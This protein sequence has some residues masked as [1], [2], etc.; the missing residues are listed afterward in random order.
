M[1]LQRLAFLLG[2]LFAAYFLHPTVT[3]AQGTAE[4]HGTLTDPS[5]GA[6]S[7]AS[8]AAHSLDSSAAIVRAKSEPNGEYSLKLAPG[9]YR[10]SIEH[11]SFARAEQEFVLTAGE[12]RA[13]DVR[14]T[15]EK[16][17]SRVVVTD[18]AEPTT[19]ENAPNLVDVIT[20]GEIEERQD[21]QLVDVLS[22]RQGASFSRLGPEGGITS[23]FL[24]G[25]NSNFTKIL[26]DGTPVNEP[27]GAI[28]LSNFTTDDVE[29]VEIVHGASSAL[30]GSDAMD[31][32]VQIFTHRGTSR[33]PE[34]I[35]DGD[36]GTFGTGRGGAQLS[37]LLGAFDYSADGGYFATTGQGPD[38]FYRD[39]TQSGNFGWKFSDTDSLRLSIRNSA[40]DAGQPGQTLLPGFAN[41]SQSSA[42]HDFSSNLNWSFDT[43]EHWHTQLTGYESRFHDLGIFAPG[44]FGRFVDSFNRA[45]FDGQ[46]T[47]LFH[48]GGATAGYMNEVE[49]GSGRHRNNQAGYV[50]VRYHFW[51]RFTAT[52]GARA[53]DN[54]SFGTRVVPR[55]G[56]SYVV[57]QGQGFWGS[58][59][60]RS[61]YG[62]GIKEPDFS[63][64]FS[65][66]P[67][68]PG[69][70]NLQP[71]R[72]ETFDAGIE[73]LLASDRVR[74]SITY[75]RNEFYDI[76]SFEGGPVTAG[77][78]FGTGTFFNTDKARAFGSDASVEIKAARWLNIFGNY[79]YDDSKVLKSPNATD[80]AL[81]PGN[82]LLKRPLNSGN[83]TFSAH[84]RGMS[85]NVIG[86]YVGRRTDSDFDS[87]I[88]N[89]VCEPGPLSPCISS[90]P[91]YFRLDLAGIVPLR[92]GLSATAHFGNLLD[93]HYQEAAG[94]PA[95]GYNY[96]VGLKYVWGGEK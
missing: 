62:L 93:R 11:P 61:S 32:V 33:K 40:S 9:R 38:D 59:R 94:Y 83:L 66:D 60:L 71:E 15:L 84:K 56:G 58:T 34:L 76:V 48:N 37:G 69:N 95:L 27:G 68:F 57:R 89:G 21:I 16:M 7:S 87:T 23:F 88:V 70:P 85:V 73:Q 14:L 22:A 80:P 52:A 92:G 13:W 74:L 75:F 45:G 50:E 10:V 63:Q 44:A 18:T 42:L 78:Q 1:R 53:E 67:C 41:L 96:R 36:A 49:T 5:G 91:G 81:I 4:I 17:S 12:S 54:A 25:G 72:S 28:D 43:G 86:S 29:K 31:G 2:S 90:D 77:C 51:K 19:A 6:I 82:R 26:V 46:S 47:Y 35:L 3:H 79:T 65:N 39:A 55:V 30:Y 24:D 8:V 20:R 64:S